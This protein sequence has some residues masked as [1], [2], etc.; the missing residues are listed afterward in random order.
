MIAQRQATSGL[1]RWSWIG[2]LA[3]SSVV[4][5]TVFACATPFVAL[6]ALSALYLDR[7]GAAVAMIAAWVANQAVGYGLLGYPH[8]AN[9]YAWGLAIGVAALLALAA[10]Q[11]T[12]PR[13]ARHGMPATLAAAFVAAFVAYE[14]ALYIS[15]FWLGGS[16]T[17]FTLS[18]VSYILQVNLLGLAALLV[19]RW[20]AQAVGLPS[21]QPQVYGAAIRSR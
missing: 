6:A 11:A 9:S 3:G 19:V 7:R 21:I 16:D 5:S 18:I 15:S 10:G 20:L 13:F 12:A 2:L 8:S 17:A 4:F 14:G 1:Q